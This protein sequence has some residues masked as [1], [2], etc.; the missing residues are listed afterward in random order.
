MVML[1][2]DGRRAWVTNTDSNSVAVVD[3][4]AG[5]TQVIP[6]GEGPQGG[7]FNSR[8]RGSALRDQAG[9]GRI[10]LIDTRL[11]KE[12]VASQPTRRLDA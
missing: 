4:K 12:V 7:V 6:T 3:L 10:A 2:K 11:S 9:P 1:S 5:S 8:K